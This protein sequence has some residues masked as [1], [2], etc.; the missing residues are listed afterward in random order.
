MGASGR[1]FKHREYETSFDVLVRRDRTID[2][3]NDNINFDT[4]RERQPIKTPTK[5]E[6]VV[7][8]VR[9]TNN[10]SGVSGGDKTTKSNFQTR[11]PVKFK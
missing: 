1:N 4:E 10:H 6:D 11:Y 5:S 8:Y 3:T 9:E 7:P 2:I